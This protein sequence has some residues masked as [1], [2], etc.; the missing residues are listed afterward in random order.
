MSDPTPATAIQDK[1]AQLRE[2]RLAHARA[3]GAEIEAVLKKYD[4]VI[5]A[6]PAFLRDRSGAFMV[7]INVAVHP[8][9]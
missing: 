1:L 4:C 9:T 6:Q 5:E 3:C 8:K 7:T 2:E